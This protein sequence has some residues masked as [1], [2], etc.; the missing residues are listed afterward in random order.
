MEGVSLVSKSL[1]DNGLTAVQVAPDGNCLYRAVAVG[2]YGSEE[3]H[4]DVRN[5]VVA[6]VDTNPEDDFGFLRGKL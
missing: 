6:L 3:R 2:F 5:T 4:L 1:V